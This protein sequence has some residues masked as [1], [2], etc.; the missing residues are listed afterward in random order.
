MVCVTIVSRIRTRRYGGD[1]LLIFFPVTLRLGNDFALPDPAHVVFAD[2]KSL[3]K[4]GFHS[5]IC[6]ICRH[7]PSALVSTLKRAQ[8]LLLTTESGHKEPTSSVLGTLNPRTKKIVDWLVYL[9]YNMY[10]AQG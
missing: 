6:R 5:L 9:G 10:D 8:G 3:R 7:G 1:S 2:R 4:I